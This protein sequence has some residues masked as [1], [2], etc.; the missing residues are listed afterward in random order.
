MIDGEPQIGLRSFDKLPNKTIQ[1]QAN[2]IRPQSEIANRIAL[3][4][5]TQIDLSL[6]ENKPYAEIVKDI[7]Q[8]II[9]IY[10]SNGIEITQEM[11]P[12]LII[13]RNKDKINSSTNTYFNI[14]NVSVITIDNEPNLIDIIHIYHELGHGISARTEIIDPEKNQML[15]HSSGLQTV[16]ITSK[17]ITGQVLEEALMRH[18]SIEYAANSHNKDVSVLRK[19]FL[20]TL[21][22]RNVIFEGEYQGL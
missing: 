20:D 1:K 3:K 16:N 19:Q 4:K 13:S 2:P 9:R 17:V 12:E 18:M 7:K 15:Y 21:L 22:E 11:F 8:D 6:P 5:E 14:E 10:K